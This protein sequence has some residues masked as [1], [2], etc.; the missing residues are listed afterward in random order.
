MNRREFIGSTVAV[1]GMMSIPLTTSAKKWHEK[2]YYGPLTAE[3]FMTKAF[4]D[5]V[6]GSGL[7]K[8]P[9]EMTASPALY[10]SYEANLQCLQRWVSDDYPIPTKPSLMFKATRLYRWEP[11]RTTQ[12]NRDDIHWMLLI[13]DREKPNIGHCYDISRYGWAA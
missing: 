9:H 10:D 12:P 2:D 13:K 11:F 7:G 5:H 8:W 1:I 4:N 3:Q 6:R